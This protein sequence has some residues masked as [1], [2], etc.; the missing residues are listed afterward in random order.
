VEAR[1]QHQTALANEQRALDQEARAAASAQ[2][3]VWNAGRL[4]L[5][6]DDLINDDDADPN[7]VGQQQAASERSLRR[8]AASLE[9]LPGPHWRELSVA[10]RRVAMILVHKGEFTAA[11]APLKKASEAAGQW[12]R[13]ERSPASRRNALLVKLC[14]LRLERQRG[15]GQTAYRLAREA[16]A[17]FRAL[18]PAMQAE[19]NGTVWM[20]SARLSMARELI[21][22]NRLEPVPALLTAVVRNSHARG[23]TQ[24][25]NLSV[26]HLV[27]SF[28]KLNR[29][30]DARH[31]CTVAREWQVAEKRI[32]QFCAEPLTAFTDRDALFP[33]LPGM[34]S[35]EDLQA[36]LSRI[37]QIIVDRHEDPRSFPLN[38]AL[39][40]AYARLAEH[41]LA[42]GQT[43]LARPAVREA[44]AIRDVLVAGDSKSPAVVNFRRRVDA[45]EKTMNAP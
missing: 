22:Q 23:L 25:R 13:A 7:I 3:A 26:A 18:P 4:E 40:R 2:Q 16:L 14:Q 15:A 43:G 34:L 1:R 11:E 30:D 24:T 35:D 39:G 21:D 10:W 19:L 6:V 44:V 9:T 27:W 28:R 32:V 42:G 29:L 12:L 17:E 36:T 8:A 45:L 5:L 41:Y 33:V 37:D 20:E 31:W 38:I